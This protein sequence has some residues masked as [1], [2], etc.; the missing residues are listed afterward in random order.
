MTRDVMARQPD[1]MQPDPKQEELTRF[2][3]EGVLVKPY[4]R[5]NQDQIRL[6]HEA[7]LSI[8]ADPGVW[9]YNERAARLF[10]A[11][12]ARVWEEREKHATC[13]RVTFPAGLINEA[14][15]QVPS[16]F[17][18]G[19]RKWENRLLLD[20][21][22]PR[23]Y[24]GSGSE[25]NIWMEVEMEDFVS[26]RDGDVKVRA[27]RFME[28]R[29]STALLSRAARLCDKLEHLDFF[30][31]PLNIQ[32][33]EITPD[34]HDVNKFFASLNNTA[35]H[36][37][38]GLT[39][40]ESLNYVVRMAELIVGGAEALRKNPII[41]FIACVF[42][43]PLQIVDDTAEKVFAIVEAGLP[44]VIS[45]SPQGGSSAPIQEPGM[46]AQ[47]NAEI[48]AGITLTQLIK[49]GA[50]VLYGSV[51]VRARLDDLHDLYGCPEF[52]NYNIDCVQLA[53]FYKI[54][55]YS[56]AGVGDA[57][58]PGIQATFEKL[59]THLYMAMSGAQYIH[60]AF[61]LLD[62][63]NSFCPLQAVLDNEHIGKIKHCLR[64]PKVELGVIEDM[65][66]TVKKVMGSPHRL[67]VRHVRKAVHAGDVSSPYRF[68]AKGLEDKVLENALDYMAKLEA[69]QAPYLN[70]G[71]REQIFKEVPGLLPGLRQGS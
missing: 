26:L 70:P 63:T 24:F 15:A 42:K 20:A 55:C 64:E 69:A 53:R 16:R 57:K 2:Y 67:Y 18:L 58:V 30:I 66:G 49:E 6:L 48:L 62:R 43:S 5:L 1:T 34:T 10:K 46:V 4:E 28:F 51:P 39:K 61:G 32:D 36:V 40:L 8:L 44:I 3:R 35:K 19:A 52:N 50:P 41:S 12:G 45:S 60:Y 7:S 54:P 37:Q 68:E 17:I 31:R 59:L 33:P 22:V 65:L 25:A 11:H 29:G 38:A 14:I 56:T 21:E 27:P 9:C 13:W 47:I 71:T 23:A